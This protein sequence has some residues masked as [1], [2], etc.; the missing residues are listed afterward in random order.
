MTTTTFVDNVTPVVASWL[1][2]VNTVTYK[3]SN[4]VAG[5][6][7]N[8][9]ALSKSADFVH[10][11][12]YGA[13]CDGVTDDTAAIIACLAANNN[14]TIFISG[15]P[16]ISAT[17]FI[18]GRQKLVFEGG[19]DAG[20]SAQPAT[21]FKKKAGMAAV[22]IVIGFG[23]SVVGGGISCAGATLGGVQLRGNTPTLRDFTVVGTTTDPN[24]GIGVRVGDTAGTN[25]N[26]W[27]LDRVSVSGMGSHGFWIHDGSANVSGPNVNAGLASACQALV[28]GG[29]GF[30][31]EYAALNTLQRC[32]S[33]QNTGI[34]V[35]FIGG[36]GSNTGGIGNVWLPGDSEG[37]AAGDTTKQIVVDAGLN[38]VQIYDSPFAQVADNGYF[39]KRFDRYND[40]QVDFTPTL[41]G[42]TGATKVGTAVTVVGT[43]AT[44]TSVA[45]GYTNGMTVA[46][47]I[48]ADTIS[49]LD[50]AFVIRN[51]TANTFDVTP[52]T[53]H[54]KDPPVSSSGR[55]TSL[56]A[57]G[58][59][60]AAYGRYTLRGTDVEFDF[61]LTTSSVA[62][63]T[64]S[65]GILLPWDPAVQS[66]G[67]GA[68]TLFS[69]ADVGFYSG[70]THTGKLA[71]TLAQTGVRVNYIIKNIGSG[72]TP[73]QLQAADISATTAIIHSGRYHA[74]SR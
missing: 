7:V 2:D 70:I 64:G 37:N 58:T 16:L 10:I 47:G 61:N 35:H 5:A 42:S 65:I 56:Q 39:T 33:E 34:G 9:T 19:P 29:E 71:L 51:V 4:G 22:G 72:L 1:N 66:G 6:P 30:R 32:L 49:N 28:N 73:S 55:T 54:S 50:G 57:C 31:M 69:V 62:N 74:F 40:T 11:K 53:D 26:S 13:V 36:V 41:W 14:R 63:L 3:A 43:T 27:V 67:V 25:T 21:Y 18:D 8:R 24:T 38:G 23:G 52:R 15:T 68:T 59:Y 46:I 45:H 60:S 20:D 12:D 48:T 44:I 17:I